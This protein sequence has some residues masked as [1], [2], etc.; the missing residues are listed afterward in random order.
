MSLQEGAKVFIRFNKL[1]PDSYEAVKAIARRIVFR[2]VPTFA[3]MVE[4]AVVVTK[5]QSKTKEALAYA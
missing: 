1:L 5:G 3:D 4:T 2:N